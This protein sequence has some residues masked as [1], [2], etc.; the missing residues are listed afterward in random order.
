M[1]NTVPDSRA[2]Q[3]NPRPEL[4]LVFQDIRKSRW[5]PLVALVSPIWIGLDWHCC[6][7]SLL[8]YFPLLRGYWLN[9][10]P[11]FPRDI[12]GERCWVPLPCGLWKKENQGSLWLSDKYLSP[13]VYRRAVV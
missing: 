13:E 1:L 9:F 6:C 4:I 10:T 3:E 5:L 7:L 8:I 12:D 2:H 11:P